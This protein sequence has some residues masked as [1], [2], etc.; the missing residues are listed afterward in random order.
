MMGPEGFSRL[1]DEQSA[2]LLLYARQWCGA[3]EDVVQEA[4]L[5]LAGQVKTPDYPVA[6]LYRVV[7]NGAI[8]AARSAQRRRRHEEA[9]A[10]RTPAWFIPSEAGQL[11]G[12]IASAA[13]AKLP[14]EQR[15]IIVAHLWGGLTFEQIALLIGSSSS[16]AHRR[17]LEGLTALRERLEKPCPT[18]PPIRS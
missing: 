18:Q 5:K 12:E 14:L 1:V 10:G 3:P 17:Y 15:E 8:S 13:L 9:A 11:D 6:W 16:T 7:R 2:A 4:F